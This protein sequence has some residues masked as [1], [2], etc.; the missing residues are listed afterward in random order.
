MDHTRSMSPACFAVQSQDI[1]SVSDL[2]FK[3][4]YVLQ[5]L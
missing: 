3:D 1:L 5:K 2:Y 4:R